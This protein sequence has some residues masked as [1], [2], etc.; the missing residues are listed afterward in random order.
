[1][2]TV[3]QAA[4]VFSDRLRGLGWVSDLLVAGSLALG[5][6]VPGVSDL[7]LVAVTAGTVDTAR[8]AQLVELHRDL[9][10][11]AATG[12]RL[13]CVYVAQVLITEPDCHHPT[14]THGSLVH[15]TL[16]GVTRAELVRHG[17]ALFGRSPAELLPAVTD[18]DVRRA[19][20]AELSGY[21]RRA[22]R[23]PWMWLDPAMADL[24]LTSMARARHAQ[25]TGQL[26]SKSAA[27]EQLAAPP[28][29]I[30]HVRDRRRSEQATSPRLRTAWIAWRDTRRTV[31]GPAPSDSYD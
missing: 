17:F 13:G 2:R 29:L 27:I 3:P 30:D 22:S 8:E 25:W 23:R 26:L 24:S 1:M 5:D 4:S 7:D 12:A 10:R 19:T 18:E 11:G 20:R 6:H 14:W 28:W 16:S 31:A 21:W 15:R 9:D